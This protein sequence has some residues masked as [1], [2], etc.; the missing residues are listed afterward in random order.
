[1]IVYAPH[2]GM[3]RAPLAHAQFF[4]NRVQ[5]HPDSVFCWL[6]SDLCV[7]LSSSAMFEAAC[8]GASAL[9]PMIPE[10]RF[11]SPAYL[12][13]LFHPAGSTSEDFENVTRAFLS[14]WRRDEEVGVTERA[15]H[16]MT[17]MIGS[18]RSE[19]VVS[20]SDR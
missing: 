8:F 14:S 2:P 16:R 20:R 3:G 15:K 10:D 13:M 17:A 4:P 1:M 7:A 18:A 19:S 6:I 12:A 11:Y 5:V 9:T